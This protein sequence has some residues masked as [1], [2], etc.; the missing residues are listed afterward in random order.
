[1]NGNIVN[2]IFI[3]KDDKLWMAIYPVG[4][5]LFSNKYPGYKWIQ[6]SYDNPNSLIDN[7]VNSIL[8]DS[9]GDICMLQVMASVFT[10]LRINSGSAF[11]PLIRTTH[12]IRTMS[13]FPCAKQPPAPYW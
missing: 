12:K 6:H 9:E 5:T 4:I 1:M 7:Q 10:I 2:D 13:L 11:F 3:D 8:E